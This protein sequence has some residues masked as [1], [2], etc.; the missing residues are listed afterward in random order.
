MNDVVGI[1]SRCWYNLCKQCYYNK[2]VV[3]K[4][5]NEVSKKYI[6]LTLTNSMQIKHFPLCQLSLIAG[7]IIAPFALR[8]KASLTNA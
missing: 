5:T 4:D 1:K 8:R 6:E 3:S 7:Q 2:R